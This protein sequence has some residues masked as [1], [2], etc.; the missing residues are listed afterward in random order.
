MAGAFR[1]WRRLYSFAMGQ[2]E[3][4][5]GIA[6]FSPRN[7]SQKYCSIPGEKPLIS[8]QFLEATFFCYVYSSIFCLVHRS[9]MVGHWFCEEW[10]GTGSA[11]TGGAKCSSLKPAPNAG[12]LLPR[13][14]RESFLGKELGQSPYVRK[15]KRT[16]SAWS[17]YATTPPSAFDWRS[18]PA[19]QN[20]SRFLS[21]WPKD[22]LRSPSGPRRREQD[23]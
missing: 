15:W 23:R 2:I 5:L 16:C 8:S 14:D 22:G 12:G 17:S 3:Y 21:K 10:S 19:L 6:V 13:L 11:K 7:A 4:F 20:I 18:P 1:I 9:P